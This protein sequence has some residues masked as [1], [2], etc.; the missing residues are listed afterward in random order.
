M[1]FQPVAWSF[2]KPCINVG[3]RLVIVCQIFLILVEIARDNY[4]LDATSFL[5]RHSFTFLDLV[6][7]DESMN[8]SE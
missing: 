7:K 1:S 5:S 8:Q 4:F 3:K 2:L 6:K